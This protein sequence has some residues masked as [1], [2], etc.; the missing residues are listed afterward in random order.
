RFVYVNPRLAEIFG[1]EA[2][3]LMDTVTVEGLVMEEDRQFVQ[4]HMDK[5]LAGELATVHYHFRGIRKDGSQVFVEV[6]GTRTDYDG[7]P[8][9]LGTLLDITERKRAEQDLAEASSLLDTLLENI[10]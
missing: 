9:V 10:P 6:L 8:A 7:R 5:R 3:E 4:E 1:Y 2:Q